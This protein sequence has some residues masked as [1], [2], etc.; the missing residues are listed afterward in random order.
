MRT[1]SGTLRP[2][3]IDWLLCSATSNPHRFD[4]TVLPCRSRWKL[5]RSRIMFPSRRSYVSQPSHVS[6][7]AGLSWSRLHDSRVWIKRS[8]RDGSSRGVKGFHQDRI[9]WPTQRVR[10]LG[11]IYRDVSSSPLIVWDVA[12][13]QMRRTSSPMGRDRIVWLPLRREPPDH[14]AHKECPLTTFPWG[15]RRLYEVGP[16]AVE[17]LSRLSLQLWDCSKRTTTTLWNWFV[18]LGL[19]VLLIIL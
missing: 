19:R 13:G 14:N 1:V 15:L 7:F 12:A 17:W 2:T 18:A 4:V 5:G 9:S 11:S 8:R 6:D 16:G 10:N 3:N